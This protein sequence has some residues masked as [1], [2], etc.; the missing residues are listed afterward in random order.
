MQIIGLIYLHVWSKKTFCGGNGALSTRS[1]PV[2]THVVCYFNPSHVSLR[3]TIIVATHSELE[4][5]PLNG[6]FGLG[7][8]E[9]ILVKLEE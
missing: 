7:G 8:D 4:G 9:G 3:G 5:V 1:T 6:T 2:L